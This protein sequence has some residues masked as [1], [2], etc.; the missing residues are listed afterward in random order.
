MTL[1][2]VWACFELYKVTQCQLFDEYTK[3][4]V[5][6]QQL[7]PNFKIKTTNS[8]SHEPRRGWKNDGNE[9]ILLLWF[10]VTSMKFVS[11]NH[12]SWKFFLKHNLNFVLVSC[13]N[14]PL[15][16]FYKMRYNNIKWKKKW[17]F[18]KNVADQQ[19]SKCKSM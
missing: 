10:S 11:V 4:N 6:I 5:K 14:F 13:C 18:K 2:I 8:I 7:S 17:C 15:L 12:G 1:Q 19:I 3:N 9:E 16:K